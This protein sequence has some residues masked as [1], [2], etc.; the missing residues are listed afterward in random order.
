MRS[1]NTEPRIVL[2]TGGAGGIGR[3]TGERFAAAGDTVVL[4]DRSAEALA[5]VGAAS[6][7]VVTDVTVVADCERMIAET[8]ERNGRLDVLVNCA[9][10]WVEGPTTEMTEEQWTARST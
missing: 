5:G 10:V 6:D 7:T 1:A 8:V 3:A 9:G 4:A 2:I